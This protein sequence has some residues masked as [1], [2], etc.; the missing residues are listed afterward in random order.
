M[1]YTSAPPPPATWTDPYGR[2]A[3]TVNVETSLSV[4]FARA[5]LFLNPILAGDAHGEWNTQR[6][7][8]ISSEGRQGAED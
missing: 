4:A 5:A 7:E 6:G 2:L 3:Q 8:W 1:K